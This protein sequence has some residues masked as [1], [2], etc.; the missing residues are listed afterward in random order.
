MAC[1]YTYQGKTYEAWEFEDLLKAMPPGDA[2]LFMPTVKP[3][4]KA[5][6]VGKTD[7]WLQLALK[8]VMGLAVDGGYDAVAFVN[9]EQSA[10]RY[11]LSKQVQSL[12]YEPKTGRLQAFDERRRTVIDK[13]DIQ[14]DQL[15][16]YIGR[17]VA[18]RLLATKPMMGKHLLDGE[19][20]KV[21][22]EGM[23]AFYDKI[24]PNAVKAITRKA[25]SQMET[26]SIPDSNAG[27]EV[28]AAMIPVNG[29]W[30][31]YDRQKGQWLSNWDQETYASD[32]DDAE[33]MSERAAKNIASAIMRDAGVMLDQPGFLITDDMRS[34]LAGGMPLFSARFTE[35]ADQAGFDTSK[36][37]YHGT[38]AKVFKS[39]RPGNGGVDEL[40]TGIYFTGDPGVAGAWAGRP[41]QGGRI[42]PAYIRKGEIFD[43]S[44]PVDYL[45]LARRV[46]DRNPVSDDER[47]A[48]QIRGTKSVTE[49]TPEE[50]RLINRADSELWRSWLQ[51]SDEDLANQIRRGS[52]NAWLDRAGYIGRKN[53]GSQIKDQVVIFRPESIRAPWSKFNPKKSSS[54][55]YLASARVDARG[56]ETWSEGLPVIENEGDYGG[57]PAVFVAYH[58]TTHSNITEFMRTGSKE[59]F[60]GQGPYFTTSPDDASSNYAGIGPDLR[61]RIDLEAEQIV[62]S[63]EDDRDFGMEVL[64]E[65]IDDQEVEAD[66][67]DDTYEDVFNEHAG[68]AAE[69]RARKQLKGDSDGLV[70]KTFVKL[71]N[72]LDTVNGEL[73]YQ[74]VEDENGDVIDETG[75]LVDWIVAARE[76]AGYRGLDREVES[77]IDALLPEGDGV[78]ASK[79][80]SA[81]V[82]HLNGAYDDSG[83]SVSAGQIVSEIAEQL[84]YDGIIMD[85]GEYFGGRRAGPF[86]IRQKGMA[87]VTDGTLHIVPFSP[88]QVKSAT[89]NS[90]AFSRTDND[91]RRSARVTETPEFKR[92]SALLGPSGMTGL[93]QSLRNKTIVDGLKR[94]AKALSDLLESHPGL[95]EQGR[96]I[97]IPTS[98]VGHVVKVVDD[99]QIRRAVVA[100]LP[101][102][103]VNLLSIKQLSADQVLSDK[104]MLEN[105]LSIDG[106]S[107]VSLAIDKAGAKSLLRSVAI[108]ATELTG[109]AD[110]LLKSGP[111]GLT[112]AGDSVFRAHN[113]SVTETEAF[114]KWFGESK[115]V[116]SQGL[117]RV[118]YHGTDG[119]FAKFDAGMSGKNYR[120][121]GGQRGLFFTSSPGTASVYAERPA[122]ARL[123]PSNP[124]DADFGDGTAN[125][126]PVYLSLQNPLVVDTTKSP[127]KFFDYNRDRLY[128]RADKA[129]ADG[130]IVRGVGGFKR[131]LFVA[132]ESG[133]VKSAI[134]NRGTFD[135][136][137]PDI[138]YSAR[139]NSVWGV[140]ENTWFDDFVFKTQDK[141]IDL[142]RVTEAI[143]KSAGKITDDINAYLQEE[144]FHGRA[145]KRVEDFGRQEL[146]PLMKAIG[147]AGLTIADVE[148]YLHARHAP[149]A[150]R[151]IA[152]RNPDNP[153]LQDGGSGMKTADAQAYMAA[154]PADVKRK[155]ESVAAKV[156]KIIGETR[157]LY[158]SYGLEDQAVVDGWGT[159]FQHYIPLQ[160]EDKEGGMGIGQ[161]FSVKGKETKG[162]TGSTRKVVDILANIALQRE[163]LIVRGEKNRVAQALVGMAW[164]NP[165]EDFWEV[166]SQAPTERVYDPKTNK[167]VERPDNMF[168]NQPNVLTAKVKDSQ[169]NVTEQAIVFN[170]DNQ[171]AMRLA[172][173]MKNIDAG[174][175]E[176]LLS[177]GAKITRYFAAINTQ[178]NPVFG[179]VNLV[180]DVQGAL[181]NLGG[182]PLAD[183][184][185]AIAADT[186]KA[187]VG[188][189]GDLRKTR[190][191]GQATSSWAKLWEEFQD[192]GGK[193]GYRD[194]FRNSA[195]RA[196]GLQEIL[197]PD[198]WM[199]SPWGKVF[200]ANGTLK[201][202]MSAAKKGAEALF[203][204]LSDYNEAMEN[205]VR[206]AAYKAALDKGMTQKQAA[207]L[208]K[209]LT[210]N[211]NRKGQIGMQ[212]GA[213]YAFFNA[214]MQGTA[215]IGQTLFTMDGG[216][217]KTLRLNKTGKTVVYGG[218]LLGSMQALMLAAAGFDDEDP[219]EFTRERSLVIPT[220]GKTYVS[221]PMPLGLH[222]IPGIGRHLTEFILSGGDKPAQR[223]ISI[224]GMFA[225]AFNPIGN[226]GLSMQTLAPTVFDPMVALTENKDWAGRPIARTSMNEATPGHT[227]HKDTASTLAKLI[228]EGINAA[229]GGSEYVAGALSPTPDQID[230]LIGQVTGGVG[231]ELSKVEQ[232]ALATMRGEELPTYKIPLVGRFVGNASGQ[233]SEGSAFYAN[234]ARLNELETEVKG[235]RADGKNAEAQKLLAS[236][237]D[238]YLITVANTAERQIQRL[239]KEKRKLI[240]DK[241]SRE[242][243]RAVEEQITAAMA[244]L[245]R[246]VEKAEAAKR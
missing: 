174:N 50:Q 91:I 211:F 111:A 28:V 156:D 182:T 138:R 186:M 82:K 160:R 103:V 181:I 87:G 135:P 61:G 175:L 162:R 118:V 170:P 197:T 39:F 57:G 115:V 212:M 36:V 125:I 208:A 124:D 153:G 227:L 142:K 229:T 23:K 233:A 178:Y 69:H 225:D 56:F 234:S 240:E 1:R 59:G 107:D 195:E 67:N 18:Q 150:N 6:F 64:Q 133:Q 45:A 161:G 92:L 144:L 155:L 230:Y 100:T 245:N 20:L 232:S 167:V 30:G 11:D 143:R 86:G 14:P 33:L 207:S 173:A 131:D 190:A 220:G 219:P 4:P 193:T 165:N 113:G 221:I 198:G 42:I 136:K 19:Q 106:A 242:Q 81:A 105:V 236:R 180:R 43:S 66:L 239:R 46:K 114:S 51:E 122:M 2:A 63:M 104:A 244:R 15:E 95:S 3:I 141:L 123:D 222:V 10:D 78:S 201:V 149:E 12:G 214:A 83:E 194:M 58:G 99:E 79:V 169:G 37:W 35:A 25:G 137:N 102:D 55:D 8:R 241:A 7:A 41:D 72:P 128:A 75:T 101:V 109:L 44:K 94:D 121:T 171:R 163:R 93:M 110:R 140:P 151:V 179:V 209:N 199:D 237:P 77:Y 108:Q 48:K 205:G 52:L 17:E 246:A 40:G 98:V 191:G 49:W 96:L 54:A 27:R 112:N 146:E 134:G 223:A 213:V 217:I 235:L 176:G 38:T 157:Q 228:S 145:A 9:G 200:T 53:D 73:T 147:D 164:A 210:V 5:P 29:A 224:F 215:R 76:V 129:G 127:D 34:K 159:M 168:K 80:L 177:V 132:F 206:L 47:R 196:E 88:N 32:P 16:D 238:A 97:D 192:V 202:P 26:I 204:W 203:S 243:V 231:R 21:G 226:A 71:A 172:A 120:S 119:D 185:A 22:G 218:V 126:M 188:I 85:A 84:G 154:L 65:Y 183:Q 152:E 158:V 187:L 24:V 184:R 90:G 70:M 13:T 117:P 166:R 216:D 139:T 148:E 130:I 31:V 74:A 189:Y 62:D 68:D 89:G 60:L 116:D